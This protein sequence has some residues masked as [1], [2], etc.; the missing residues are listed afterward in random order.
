MICRAPYV[1]LST[2]G[3]GV[4]PNT[5][6]QYQQGRQII[7]RCCYPFFNKRFTKA[8]MLLL[9]AAAQL[10]FYWANVSESKAVTPTS[11]CFF[12][13]ST[14]LP[15]FSIILPTD[16]RQFNSL[17]FSTAQLLLDPQGPSGPF[18]YSHFNT[19]LTDWSS[20]FDT[21]GTQF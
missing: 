9:Q 7:R 19:S 16:S 20:L 4:N 14:A 8:M 15:A 11:F 5:N 17:S 6:Q 13:S 3:F 12:C 18:R 2:A 10:A 1:S 21:P